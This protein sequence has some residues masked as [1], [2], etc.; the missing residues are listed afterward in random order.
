MAGSVNV[1]VLEEPEYL[2][3]NDLFLVGD[4]VRVVTQLGEVFAASYVSEDVARLLQ[5]LQCRLQQ[6]AGP[7]AGLPRF[8][9]AMA[10]SEL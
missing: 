6:L 2:R 4:E 10:S 5:V 3:Q 7:S 8:T 9:F 1:V